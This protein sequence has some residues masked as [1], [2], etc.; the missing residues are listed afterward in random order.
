M[1]TST[2]THSSAGCCKHV[3]SVRDN[4]IVNLVRGL[5]VQ[6]RAAPPTNKFRFRA[7]REIAL[8]S[9][10]IGVSC[11][12]PRISLSRLRPLPRIAKIPKVQVNS[13][14]LSPHIAS[15]PFSTNCNYRFIAP[16][17]Y[18]W[19]RNYILCRSNFPSPRLTKAGA[20]YSRDHRIPPR[21]EGS[22]RSAIV[23]FVDLAK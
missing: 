21:W 16:F 1:F 23:V 11:C 10:P 9:W 7:Y 3:F 8:F 6:T 22:T 17:P 14:S 5:D 13:N 4:F 18:K 2:K 19:T 12:R 20:M 15:F